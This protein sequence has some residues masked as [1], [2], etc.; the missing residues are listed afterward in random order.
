M[1]EFSSVTHFYSKKSEPAVD[2]LSFTVGSGE[3]FGFLGPNGAG[4]STTIKLLCGIL[5]LTEGEI[6][7][8]GHSMKSDSLEAKKIMAYCP[9]EPNFFKKLTGR[10]YV[11]F[12]ADIFSIPEDVRNERLNEYAARFEL[13][14]ALDKKLSSYSHGMAQKLSLIAALVHDPKVL[15][16]DEP[17]VGLDPR[18]ARLVKDIIRE[19]ADAGGTVFFSTHV[20]EVAEDICDR[21]GIIDEGKIIAVGKTSELRGEG[22]LEEFFLKVT[23]NDLETN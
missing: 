5:Q 15:V 7:V 6:K 11:N 16:L 12:I 10:R 21:I 14:N 1:I 20:L 13:T 9:D 17:L 4:K 18:S 23:E 22:S 8:E 19:R 2:G 3:V